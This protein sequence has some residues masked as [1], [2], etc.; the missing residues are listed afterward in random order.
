MLLIFNI[1]DKEIG[2]MPR[3]IPPSMCMGT[4]YICRASVD[5]RLNLSMAYDDMGNIGF[6]Y[7]ERT[8]ADATAGETAM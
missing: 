1:L 5:A 7:I 8:R 4:L 2:G 3:L 6:L